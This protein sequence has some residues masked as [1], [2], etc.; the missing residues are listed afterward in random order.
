MSILKIIVGAAM[1]AGGAAIDVFSGGSA[2]WLGNALISAGAGQVISGVGSLIQGSPIKGFATTLR[3]S[4]APWR[5]CYGRCRTG[6]TLVYMHQ[7]GDNN[8]MLD[9]VVVLNAHKSQ[10]VDELLCDQQRIQIDTAA[11]PT[12]GRAGYTIPAPV[13]GAGTSFTPVQQRMNMTSITRTK[14]VVTVVLPQDIPYLDAGDQVLIENV[15]GDATLNGIFQVAEI[16]S[17][18]P[19]AGT[20]IL[21]FKFLCGGVDAAVEAA[22]QCET[23]W[24]DYGRN[25]YFEALLGNQALGETFIGM[26]AGTP[27]QGTGKL[28]TPASPQNAGGT[29]APNPWT[30]YCSL[31]GKTAVFLRLK[32]DQKYFPA[33]LP[34]ISFH[35]RGK[36]DIYDPRTDSYGYTENAVLCIADLLSNTT[37]GFK[38]AYGT[39]IPT[40]QLAADAEI[41]DQPV[42][43]ANGGTEPRYA[44]NG[45]FELSTKRGEIL[46][47]MLTA[48]AG[49]LLYLG[50][51]FRI[52]PAYWPSAGSP[53]VQVTLTEIASAP[54]RWRNS[55][56][57]RDL[58]NGVK[59]TYISPANKWQ[60]TDYPYYAQDTE[61]GYNGPSEHGGD[62]LL[63]ADNGERRWMELHLPFVIS[64]S[65]AQ[66]IAKIELLRRRGR[67][68]AMISGQATAGYGASGTFPLTL[69]GY[70]FTPLDVF[71]ATV[72]FLGFARKLLEV[73]SVRFEA[74]DISEGERQVV[75]LGTEVDLQET[76]SSI[77]DWSSTEELSAQAFVQTLIPQGTYV[78][79]VPLPW[80]PG[81][82]APVA[83]DAFGGPS[84][85]GVEAIPGG[86]GDPT[87]KVRIKGTPSA[88][89]LD[90]AI[91]AP[92][93][94][95]SASDNGGSIAPGTYV[96]GVT[97]RDSSADTHALTPY[98]RLAVVEMGGTGAGKIDLAI[99]WGSGDDGGEVYMGRWASDGFV[100]HLQRTLSPGQLTTSITSFDE[101]TQGGPDPLFSHFAIAWRD[102]E[103]GGCFGAQV[104]ART[105]NTITLAGNGMTVDQWADYPVSLLAKVAGGEV[106]LLNLP[107]AGN[108]ASSGGSFVLTIGPNAGGHQVADLTT[109]LDVGDVVVMRLRATFTATSFSDPNIANGIYPDGATGV[110]AGNVAVVLTGQD[111]GDVQTIAGVELDTNGKPTIFRLADA[112]K[113]TPLTGDLVVICTSTE[114]E[115]PMSVMKVRNSSVSGVVGE[116]SVVAPTG[117]TRLFQ[118]RTCDA[119]GLTGPDRLAPMREIYIASQATTAAQAPALVGA[120]ASWVEVDGNRGYFA[121][122]MHMPADVTHL[123][124]AFCVLRGP[125]GRQLEVSLYAT[126]FAAGETKT[127]ASETITRA[128]T[129]D[130]WTA[131]FYCENEFGALTANPTLHQ[132]L[133][134]STQVI[135]AAPALTSATATWV[136]VDLNRGYFSGNM[137]MPATI[138]HLQRAFARL[139]GPSGRQIE[140]SVYAG[141]FSA[142]QTKAWAS[143]TMDRPGTA[144][145]WTADFYTENEVGALTTNPSLHQTLTTH[146]AIPLQPTN[147]SITEGARYYSVRDKL[148][149]VPLVITTTLPSG[150]NAEWLDVDVSLDGG[151]TWG[152]VGQQ[153]VGTITVDELVP[154]AAAQW[155]VRITAQNSAYFTDRSTGA[156]LSNTLT[157]Q[158]VSAVGSDACCNATLGN[159]TYNGLTWG[160]DQVQYTLAR[161][162]GSIDPNVWTTKFQRRHVDSNRNPAPADKYNDG[163]WQTVFE[164]EDWGYTRWQNIASWGRPAADDSVYLYWEFRVVAIN[165]K[166]PTPDETV[167]QCWSNNTSTVSPLFGPVANQSAT[168]PTQVIDPSTLG[169]GLIKDPVTG[170]VGAGATSWESAVVDARFDSLP[171]GKWVGNALGQVV[172]FDSA[173]PAWPSGGWMPKIPA[174]ASGS[175]DVVQDG[176]GIGPKY[177]ILTGAGSGLWQRIPV[178]AG[179]TYYIMAQMRSSNTAGGT[180]QGF[181]S[182]RWADVSGNALTPDYASLT[183]YQ[184]SWTK[185]NAQGVAPSNAKYLYLTVD[186]SYTLPAGCDVE[187]WVGRCRRL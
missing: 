95:C 63:A 106:Q 138:A 60:S 107:V 59:G 169:W 17:R 14:G 3:N 27:W 36:N 109:L 151:A 28:C 32:Y 103:H 79:T 163:T 31:Q 26:T 92:Q 105:E 71:E 119:N 37:W 100:M 115:T 178:T 39:E 137:G 110:E 76:D 58:F 16:V 170:Q 166:E 167:L 85:F 19:S 133:T 15:P 164:S 29:P 118:V 65:A 4:I 89:A 23:R 2:S 46:Q 185:L 83:G 88:N 177:V 171:V 98:Q 67:G 94:D 141:D 77:Y 134:T 172:P 7:W 104:Q 139:L 47:N 140:V 20:N 82:A 122:T 152:Y 50:G 49:R 55:V 128:S 68:G 127:W 78:E 1:V 145:A 136:D 175:I 179:Q 53:P 40:A 10:A 73:A 13:T 102:E 66:R 54:Y 24:A 121:G 33:G 5:I 11:I 30:R 120:T 114:A 22:G 101:T 160:I 148:P 80:S 116:L 81:Y 61:H 96:V 48:C 75:R 97:A 45:Q 9:L 86:A 149:H 84:S 165:R 90:T 12:S 181:I 183:G 72:P 69:A 154:A 41:C 126:D 123:V 150:H 70:R 143:D 56:P 180:H 187:Y 8:Q 130:P 44:C 159:L 38:A 161:L 93:F 52:Q 132:A 158:P 113:I 57:I 186:E 144:E 117:I 124:R 168:M 147:V 62:I 108:T 184:A 51:V 135:P 91:A 131:D 153:P 173:T 176:T 6:G 21:T 156:R 35:L 174:G 42:A 18:V 64:S 87:A 112:W 99:T 74:E 155:K 43:L 111:A 182:W 142:N 129:Q 146:G 125:S 25:V 162:N 157:V 34:Q